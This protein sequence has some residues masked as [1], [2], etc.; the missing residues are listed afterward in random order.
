MKALGRFVR[1]LTASVLGPRDDDR[2][3]EELAEHLALLTEDNLRAGL[4]L[5]EA[6][7]QA[8]LKL[9]AGDAVGEAYQD[10]QRLR[11][12]ESVVQDARYALRQLR[13]APSFTLT[14]SLT[15]ALGIGVT[16]AIF[17]LFHHALLR[18]LPVAD[19]YRL[20]NLSSTEP[21][22]GSHVGDLAAGRIGSQ[23]AFSYPMFRDLER[24]QT[25][26]TGIAAHKG[27]DA[28]VSFNRQTTS[29]SGL[30][31]S[32]SYF[33]VL[34]VQPA[35]GRL[36]SPADDRAVGEPAIVVLS[37]AYW[38]RHLGSRP[39]VVGGTLVVNGRPMTIV[40]VAPPGFDGTTLGRQPDLY[41]PITMYGYMNQDWSG[42]ENRHS[43]WALLF[44]RL[45]PGVTLDQARASMNATYR[46]LVADIEV[47]LRQGLNGE[48]LAQYQSAR[49]VVAPGPYGQSALREVV[50]TPLLLLLAVSSAVLI[51]ACV[52]VA[53]VLLA[54]ATTRAHEMTVRASLGA[55]R[56]RLLLQLLTESCLLAALGG[57]LGLFIARITLSTLVW[58]VP[59]GPFATAAPATLS[60]AALLS[61]GAITLATGVLFGFLP[62]IHVATVDLASAM[63][64]RSGQPGGRRA[65]L[66]RTALATAQVGLSMMLLML[67]GVF[68]RS[69]WH[70]SQVD[71]GMTREHLV[72]FSV[73]PELTGYTPQRATAFYEQLVDTL[74]AQPGVASVT[75]SFVPAVAGD[76][77]GKRVRLES[78]TDVSASQYN[79]VG[80]GYFTTMGIPLIAGREITSADTSSAPRVAVVNEAF[81]KQFGLGRNI[82]GM[83]MTWCC[84]RPER[85][86]MGGV[87]TEIVGLVKDARY[88]MIKDAAPPVFYIP[89]RQ[90][91]D[92]G[93]THIYVRS[94]SDPRPL[95][96]LVR[97]VV[98]R[99]DPNLPIDH[100][101]TME[102]QARENVFV[103]W[104]IGLL[105]TGFAVLATLLAS[106]GLY[107]V[108]A[109]TVAQRRTEI[110]LR[111][112]LG[113]TPRQIR[114]MVL[115]RVAGMA[116]VGVVCGVAGAVAAGRAARTLL[117]EVQAHDPLVLAAA[118]LVVTVVALGA[119]GIPAFMA[120]R[121]D[122]M[123]A[124]RPE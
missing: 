55:G 8:R 42:F 18:P 61:S 69:L 13:R 76:N 4:P 79:E 36:F 58:L 21:R 95:F 123:Q 45:R 105:S 86:S 90:T 100:L 44:A 19:P 14:I 78:A 114:G 108:L 111:M 75:G 2:I 64:S 28:S 22:T 101:K 121:V 56:G 65:A 32:G 104:L 96:V 11:V 117:F 88:S 9:G 1:R 27:F 29:G 92:R 97:H 73:A 118:A 124:L 74:A 49:L 102:Q 16:T 91:A 7:R 99:L 67:A 89:Y 26:F 106:I 3:R 50:W 12:L 85:S 70:V 66:V 37:D 5:D 46:A 60:T 15:L 41:V 48:A 93:L 120:S 115:R 23:A 122:P 40:G 119:G 34:G 43:Y 84:A 68:A 77:R 52:N 30:A 103:D 20:V 53:N 39:D 38:R 116:A 113:A 47:P 81:A 6:R 31:V 83:R 25:A 24:L 63:R 54:R 17:S 109:Y 112:A 72:T 62:A 10:E 33:P 94:A 82:V 51:I 107:G 71:I 87:D 57:T 98:G 35:L 110:G 80:S 59:D